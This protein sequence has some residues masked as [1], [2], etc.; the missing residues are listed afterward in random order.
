MVNKHHSASVGLLV[1]CGCDNDLKIKSV[2]LFPVSNPFP[3]N[4]SE[5][6]VID[7]ASDVDKA[8]LSILWSAPGSGSNSSPSPKV[9]PSFQLR[10]STMVPVSSGPFLKAIL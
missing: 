2:A 1:F 6:V 8:F 10:A 4:T 9:D 7:V 3:F 5:P